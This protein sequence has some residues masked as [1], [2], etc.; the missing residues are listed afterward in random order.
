[1]K[2][3]EVESLCKEHDSLLLRPGAISLSLIDSVA[4]HS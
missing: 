2:L 1:M 3:L 4:N